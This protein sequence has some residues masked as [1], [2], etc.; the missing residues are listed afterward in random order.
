M[1]TDGLCLSVLIAGVGKNPPRVL[2]KNQQEGPF[3]PKP[4]R[5]TIKTA[6]ETRGDRDQTVTVTLPVHPLAGHALAV[7]RS[8]R[9]RDGRRYVDLRHPDG[10]VFRLPEG[11]TDRAAPTLAAGLAA[12]GLRAWVQDLLRLAA[13]VDAAEVNEGTLKLDKSEGQERTWSHPEQT[14]RCRAGPDNDSQSDRSPAGHAPIDGAA[15]VE[16]PSDGRRIG[17]AG[18]PG[19]QALVPGGTEQGGRR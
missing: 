1:R 12:R 17:G 19:F 2:S 8:V 4:S 7:V 18:E 5:R 3:R 16:E 13:A 14:T 15:G 6:S 9:C 11:Y 10:H